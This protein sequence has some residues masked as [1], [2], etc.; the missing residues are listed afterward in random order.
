MTDARTL[1]QEYHFD[2]LKDMARLLAIEPASTL[3][4]AYVDALAGRLFTPPF[5]ERGL[6]LLGRRERETLAELQ[7]IGGRALASRLRA[8]L[9]HEG[10]IES[11][12]DDPHSKSLYGTGVHAPEQR[13]ISFEDVMGR[14]MAVGVVCGQEI[15]DSFFSNRTKVHYDNVRT[16][17]IPDEVSRHLPEPPPKQALEVQIEQQIQ[18]RESS[19]RAFQRDLYFYWSA[20]HTNPLSL[21][22]EGRLYQRDLRLVNEALTFPAELGTSDETGIPRLLF[23]R[24]LLT[25]LGLLRAHDGSTRGVDH[26]PFLGQEAS[27]RVQQTYIHWRDGTFWNELLSTKRITVLGIS[28]RLDPAP[29]AIADARAVVLE[30]MADLHRMVLQHHATSAPAQRWVPVDRL[31]ETLRLTDYD[32]LFPRGYRPGPSEYYTYYGYTSFRS[33]YISYGNKMGW[34]ISPRFEDEAEGWEVVEAGFVRAMLSEPLYW[35]GL[36]DLGLSGDRVVAYRLTPAGEWALGLGRE[37]IIPEGEG[38]VIVQPNFEIIALDPI[39]DLRLAKLDEFAERVSSER[40]ITYRLSRESVY[41]AQRNGWSARRIIDTLSQMSDTQLPQNVLRT[42]E[43]WQEIHERIKIHRRGHMLQAVNGELLDRLMQDPRIGSRFANRVDQTVAIIA[44]R[45]GETDELVRNLQAFGYPPAR[46]TSADEKPPPSFT[47]DAE[48]QL[49]FSV[50]LPSI[51]LY[52]QIAPLTTQDEKGRYFL[53]RTAVEEA[54]AGG[55]SV[56]EILE[57]LRTYHLGPLPRWVTLKVR[58]WGKYYGDVSLQTITLIQVKDKETLRELM[59][60]PEFDGLLCPFEP[61]DG[62]ALAVIAEEDLE[63]LYE[64]LAERN[65]EVREGLE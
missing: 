9:V 55:M 22:K 32:F 18:V 2:L 19:A 43:E 53:T 35:M 20:A 29:Q 58:A 26:P 31:L 40:A 42:L 52:R 8:H 37:L 44:P 23:A 17:Y 14:L 51:Y 3:K 56:D 59:D 49:R 63:A 45:R 15:M 33:P 28:S 25:D 47:L 64:R 16:V 38:K 46:T 34:S 30:H 48:G 24:L 13:R 60:E 7:R 61:I 6:S 27:D 65:I 39:S 10:V 11:G 1:L 41:R 4:T 5:I 50:A 12:T 57:R 62:K 54:I 36:V 21:T